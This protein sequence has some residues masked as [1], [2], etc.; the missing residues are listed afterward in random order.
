[1]FNSQFYALVFPT[2]VM[3]APLVAAA[4]VAYE[5]APIWIPIVVSFIAVI[6][7]AGIQLVSGRKEV[8]WD[9]AWE[10]GTIVA[11]ASPAGEV[12]VGV[13]RGA[14]GLAAKEAEQLAIKAATKSD[15]AVAKAV[16]KEMATI[17]DL[18]TGAEIK[19]GLLKPGVL[20]E[21]TTNWQG[22]GKSFS[23]SIVL[24]VAQIKELAAKTGE[25]VMKYAASHEVFHKAMV[26]STVFWEKTFP[27]VPIQAR[28]W[29]VN[30]K[31]FGT[32]INE[33][34]TDIAT[35]MKNPNNFKVLQAMGRTNGPFTVTDSTVGVL[36]AFG[37]STGS[38]SL[39]QASNAI[40]K[41]ADKVASSGGILPAVVPF[42]PAI[43]KPV[44]QTSS[45][46]NC[47]SSSLQQVKSSLPTSNPWT[48]LTKSAP[49]PTNNCTCSAPVKPAPAPVKS[50][51]APSKS[52][53]K[54]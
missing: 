4:G 43:I 36:K 31:P 29:I 53:G 24:D 45:Y 41:V 37:E 28:N 33:A 20:G 32:L 15:A 30:N 47:T 42:A 6:G 1:M 39:Q 26:E 8:N 11:M 19:N 3:V 16:A 38:K 34:V 52:C 7:A 54:K 49:K 35:T 48:A 51:P 50:A 44:P 5:T 17:P 22:F 21:T 12:E 25:D 46:S 10:V 2:S 9:E 14:E 18:L 13:V 27:G 40:K 23:K